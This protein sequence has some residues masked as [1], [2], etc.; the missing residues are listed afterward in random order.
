MISYFNDRPFI[1]LAGHRELITPSLWLIQ[2]LDYSRDPQ[3]QRDPIASLD[4]VFA[5]TIIS[6]SSSKF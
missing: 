1:D 3:P 5:S 2:A 4:E 6:T